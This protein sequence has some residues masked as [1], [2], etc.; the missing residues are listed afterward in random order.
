MGPLLGETGLWALKNYQV[1]QADK[2][3][4]E[5]KKMA[6]TAS[7]LVTKYLES[8]FDNIGKE[9]KYNLANRFGPKK[10]PDKAVSKAKVPIVYSWAHY[11]PQ[12]WYEEMQRH[13]RAVQDAK[14]NKGAAPDF[15]L[16]SY[17][18][19]PET[20]SLKHKQCSACKQR[21]YCSVDCQRM[22][23]KKGHSKEC[24]VLAAKLKEQGGK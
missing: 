21:W 2:G 8:G 10:C 15:K 14:E 1:R 6:R 9:T 17:C 3:N 16:C 19:C 13:E 22:D 24:K 23:W 11:A 12:A 18:S 20:S 5:K 4:E 7:D